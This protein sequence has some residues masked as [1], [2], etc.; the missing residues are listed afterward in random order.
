VS[1]RAVPAPGDAIRRRSSS[2]PGI[3]GTAVRGRWGG[4]SQSVCLGLTCASHEG[5]PELRAAAWRKR[6]SAI[7][8]HHQ[9]RI[10]VDGST[11][12]S[13]S[14]ATNGYHCMPPSGLDVT[15]LGPWLAAARDCLAA[16]RSIALHRAPSSHCSVISVISKRHQANLL[17]HR[18]DCTDSMF[19]CFITSPQLA[20]NLDDDRSRTLLLLRHCGRQ[21][22]CIAELQNM[23]APSP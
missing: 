13:L 6:G 11:C 8:R 9:L 15:V 17:K 21:L 5:S 16:S 12:H 1:S 19:L 23:L 10:G 4:P 7:S 20:C 2:C 18:C 3:P 14:I 22:A